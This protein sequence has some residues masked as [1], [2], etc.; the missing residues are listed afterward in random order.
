MRLAE[1]ATGALAPRAAARTEE[2]LA[3]DDARPW[4]ALDLGDGVRAVVEGGL[5]RFESSL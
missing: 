3:L 2:I 4:T 5:L 1:D